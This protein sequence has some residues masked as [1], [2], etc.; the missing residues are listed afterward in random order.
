V[1]PSDDLCEQQILQCGGR[2]LRRGISFLKRLATFLK[3]KINFLKRLLSFLTGLGRGPVGV[4]GNSRALADDLWARQRG[5]SARQT[6]KTLDPGAQCGWQTT[7]ALIR[8]I[9]ARV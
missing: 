7:C 2:V 9:G 4:A 3:R 1:R 8:A 6:T 5:Q